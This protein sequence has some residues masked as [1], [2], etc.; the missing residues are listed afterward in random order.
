MNSYLYMML[1]RNRAGKG[2]KGSELIFRDG[3]GDEDFQD[4]AS[5]Y[6]GQ[7]SQPRQSLSEPC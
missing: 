1:S 3:E 7:V 4:K 2:K 5:D 6:R